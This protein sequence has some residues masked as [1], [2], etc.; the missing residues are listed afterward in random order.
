M[1]FYKPGKY[2]QPGKVAAG[3]NRFK[4]KLAFPFTRSTRSRHGSARIG[5]YGVKNDGTTKVVFTKYFSLVFFIILGCFALW[6]G[7]WLLASS[8]VFRLDTIKVKGNLFV[9][10]HDVLQS[11]S[12][13]PGMSLLKINTDELEENITSLPWVD[14]VSVQKQWP[15]TLDIQV[16][17]QNPIAL[18]NVE[19]KTGLTQLFYVNKKGH[20]FAPYEQGQDLDYPVLT[21]NKWT[22][23]EKVLILPKGGLEESALLLLKLA[24]K[25]NPILPIQSISEV[26]MSDKHGIIVY[27]VDQPFPIYFGD[28]SIHTK[29]YRLV[30]ILERLY[31]KKTIDGI[32]S[33]RMDYAQ[34]KILV[35]RAEI[36]K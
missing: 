9:Q 19:R 6:G 23:D 28:E 33:I 2:K 21:G 11:A 34:N 25:G 20:L 32:K 13:E 5:S 24:S 10:R 26:H 17:E 36:D 4:N 31:R 30:K 18:I 12:I 16:R 35:A 1:T 15:S 8:D 29:Y 14:R 7:H 27:L 22:D 3:W